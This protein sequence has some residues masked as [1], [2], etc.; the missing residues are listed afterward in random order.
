[1]VGVLSNGTL[2]RTTMSRRISLLEHPHGAEN[3]SRT[4]HYLFT[5]QAPHHQGPFGICASG[6]SRT[7]MTEVAGT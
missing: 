4:H 6:G 1:M 2:R 5:K 3:G 7:H